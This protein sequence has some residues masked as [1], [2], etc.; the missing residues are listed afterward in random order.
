MPLL[1]ILTLDNA[2]YHSS[3]VFVLATFIILYQNDTEV[4][5]FVLI[6]LKK[7]DIICLSKEKRSVY[8]EAKYL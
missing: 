1:I 7:Y 4:N 3:N 8:N 2:L 5:T 6:Y